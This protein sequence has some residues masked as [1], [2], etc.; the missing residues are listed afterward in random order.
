MTIIKVVIIQMV[1]EKPILLCDTRIQDPIPTVPDI[2]THKHRM[3]TEQLEAVVHIKVVL[4]DNHAVPNRSSWDIVDSDIVGHYTLKSSLK[5]KSEF[6]A[7]LVMISM[8]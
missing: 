8:T 3:A 5:D 6:V 7:L 2:P 1:R 4:E